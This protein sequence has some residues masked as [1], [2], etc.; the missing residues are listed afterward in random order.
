MSGKAIINYYKY[1]KKDKLRNPNYRNHLIEI[2]FRML[3]V[4]SSGG[5]KT[6]FICE[7][8][9]RMSDTFEEI[10]ICVRTKHEPLYDLLEKKGRGMVKFYENQVPDIDEFKDKLVRLV[11]FDDLILSKK[12]NERIGEY[13]VRSR[14][15]NMSCVYLAQSYYMI[16]KLIRQNCNYLVLKKLGTS[17]D[18]SYILREYALNLTKEELMDLYEQCTN[19]PQRL[20]FLMIDM[21]NPDMRWRCNFQPIGK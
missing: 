5:G 1:T 7:L 8:I 11:I 16:P 20:N 14:K 13:F 10:I 12:L 15:Y 19:D 4:A 9:H 3:C 18:I 6:N 17:K 2:P 21:Q